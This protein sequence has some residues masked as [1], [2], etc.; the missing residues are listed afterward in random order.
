MLRSVFEVPFDLYKHM[1]IV[2]NVH[3]S[4]TSVKFPLQIAEFLLHR[5]HEHLVT[6]DLRHRL[7]QRKKRHKSVMLVTHSIQM[8]FNHVKSVLQTQIHI[9]AITH[10]KNRTLRTS[11]LLRNCALLKG[12]LRCTSRIEFLCIF[13]FDKR[14]ETH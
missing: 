4:L 3:W 1:L 5:L 10:R 14:S 2:L 9:V 12:L 6:A 8:T 13:L 7:K 11:R